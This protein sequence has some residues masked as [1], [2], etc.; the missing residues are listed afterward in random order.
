M[1]QRGEAAGLTVV[2]VHVFMCTHKASVF[3]MGFL[4][5]D[6]ETLGI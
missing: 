2:N 3:H 4:T 6:L 5:Q 1:R